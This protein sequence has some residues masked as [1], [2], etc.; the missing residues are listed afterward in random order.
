MALCVAK[1]KKEGIWNVDHTCLADLN[2]IYKMLGFSE[3]SV[4]KESTSNVGDL[5]SIPG[6]GRFLEKGKATHSTILA[7]RIPRARKESDSIE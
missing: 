2:N 6:S 3:S 5:G 4:D 7:W 1:G